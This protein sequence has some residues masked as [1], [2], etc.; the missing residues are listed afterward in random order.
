ME[1]D[2]TSW[3]ERTCWGEEGVEK[4]EGREREGREGERERGWEWETERAEAASEKR[5]VAAAEGEAEGEQ[6]GRGA[7]ACAAQASR[8]YLRAL[9]GGTQDGEFGSGER[10]VLGERVEK[11][12]ARVQPLSDP[13]RLEHRPTVARGRRRIWTVQLA[14][15]LVDVDGERAERGAGRRLGRAQRAPLLLQLVQNAHQP[16]RAGCVPAPKREPDSGGVH[17]ELVGDD[18]AHALQL[19]RSVDVGADR[20]EALWE[21]LHVR[22]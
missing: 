16:A 20:R 19:A 13:R 21:G 4:E 8:G 10:A 18:G 2:L 5:R 1:R 6:R 17:A 22:L 9:V 11:H 14:G 15:A 3:A 7:G 12:R